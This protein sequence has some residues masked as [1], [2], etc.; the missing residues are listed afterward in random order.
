MINAQLRLILDE[1]HQH[2]C[3]LYGERLVQVILFGSQA[4]HDA[5]PESDVDV[6]VVLKG[7]VNMGDEIEFTGDMLTDM[8]LEYG[9]P[10]VCIFVSEQRFLYE[11]NSL[12]M[13]IQREGILV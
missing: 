13:N 4:R 1:L 10:I 9:I 2:L 3:Q 11:E 5:T 7:D 12:F 6:L 8:L